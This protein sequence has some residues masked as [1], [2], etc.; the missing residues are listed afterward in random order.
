MAS[1]TELSS[2]YGELV[3]RDCVNGTLMPRRLLPR[4]A[5]NYTLIHRIFQDFGHRFPLDRAGT[6]VPYDTNLI[7]YNRTK[8]R[9]RP[10]V[11]VTEGKPPRTHFSVAP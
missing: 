7:I 10:M 5:A 11:K 4:T 2:S 3:G 1:C 6:H 9:V 8:V